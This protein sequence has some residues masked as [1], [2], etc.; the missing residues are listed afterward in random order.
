M[1][2]LDYPVLGGVLL[3]VGCWEL[4]GEPDESQRDAAVRLVA[5]GQR[6][7]YHRTLPT[8]AW[9]N[10][11][12]VVDAV[13]PD[14]LDTLVEEYAGQQAVDLRRVALAATATLG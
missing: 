5:L 10:V 2:Q 6:F 1:P 4:T 12:A 9:T 13:A 11:H 3:A 8:L 7:G 14:V